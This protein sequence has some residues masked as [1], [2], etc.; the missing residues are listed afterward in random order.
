MDKMGKNTGKW[1]KKYIIPQ[2]CDL[3]VFIGLPLG[4]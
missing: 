1:Y 2:V 4:I 3:N